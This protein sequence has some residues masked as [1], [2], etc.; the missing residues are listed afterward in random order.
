[1]EIT[2]EQK[3]ASKITKNESPPK[4]NFHEHCIPDLDKQLKLK[5]KKINQRPQTARKV[6]VIS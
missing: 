6:N 2:H 3:K 4:K 5:G 1:V